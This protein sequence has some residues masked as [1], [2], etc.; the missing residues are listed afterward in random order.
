MI[1]ADVHTHSS[2]S[3]DSDEPLCQMALAAVNKGLKTL[4]V[5]EHHD[6]DHPIEGEFLLDVPAY[7]DELLRVRSEFSDKLEVLFGVEL[8]LLDYAAPR[9]YEFARGA[10]FDFIIGSAHQIDD[11]DPYY[12]EYFDKMGDKNGISHFFNSMLSS[13]KA[14]DDFDILGHLDYIV[15]YSHAKSYDPPDYR[16][17]IDE[18][19]KT[20]ISKG[21]GIEINTA[22]IKSL[23]YPHPHPFVLRRYKELG[24]EIV[25]IGSDAHER[26]RVAAGFDKAEQALRAEGFEYYAVFRKRKPEFI[27]I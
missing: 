20:V 15:R 25:T 4:C 6:F 3:S 11:L 27:H 12:P 2:F 13:V 1:F 7:R 5:T 21:K 8:G 18:I 10:D 23:G 19:L 16:E 17:V 22:G 9:L 26:T 24:G 14:F